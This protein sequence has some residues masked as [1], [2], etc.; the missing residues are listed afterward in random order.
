M[1]VQAVRVLQAGSRA[2]LS[3]DRSPLLTIRAECSLLAL[4]PATSSPYLPGL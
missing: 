3:G 2:T 4:Q 1:H